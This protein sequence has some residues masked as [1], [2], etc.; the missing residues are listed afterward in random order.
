MRLETSNSEN[1]K[2]YYVAKTK[3]KKTQKINMQN[4]IVN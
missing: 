2:K 1:I 4:S 3:T